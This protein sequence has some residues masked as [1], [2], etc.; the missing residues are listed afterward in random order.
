MKLILWIIGIAA[1]VLSYVF[2][3]FYIFWLA[4]AFT[5]VVA[6]CTVT[7]SVDKHLSAE[8]E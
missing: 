4:T 3:S 8:S 1:L 6:G 5:A 7:H 2:E